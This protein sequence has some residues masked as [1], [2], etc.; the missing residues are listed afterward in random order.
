MQFI[1]TCK[2]YR[3]N[4]REGIRAEADGQVW[5]QNLSGKV[6]YKRSIVAYHS[7][8]GTDR[9]QYE[10]P[11]LEKLDQEGNEEKKVELLIAE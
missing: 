9:G 3:T 6:F 7:W 1:Y 2:F 5:E 8:M 4:G 10:H 11:I